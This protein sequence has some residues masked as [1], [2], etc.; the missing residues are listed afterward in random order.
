MPNRSDDSEWQSR[1]ERVVSPTVLEL[2]KADPALYGPLAGRLT[3]FWAR[4]DESRLLEQFERAVGMGDRDRALSVCGTVAELSAT[5]SAE[6]ATASIGVWYGDDLVCDD[7][8]IGP[9]PI[10]MTFVSPDADRFETDK[11]EIRERSAETETEF[12]YLI[13]IVPQR[14]DALKRETTQAV[15]TDVDEAASSV[16]TAEST[17][18]AF[19][20]GVAAGAA[21]G[22][23]SSLAESP[24]TEFELDDPSRRSSVDDSIRNRS[25]GDELSDR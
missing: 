5:E 23:S 16:G 8:Q 12:V 25:P 10:G 21:A 22:G 11:L 19:A 14:L 15:P 20:S 17:S 7:V 13:A 9:N 3:V 1:R 24:P 6:A 18:L 4:R 2:P